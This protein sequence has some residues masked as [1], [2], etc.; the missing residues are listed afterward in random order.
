M[1]KFAFIIHPIDVRRDA[2]RKYPILKLLPTRAIESLALRLAP[3][4]MSHISGIESPTGAQAEGWLIGCPLSPR[5]FLELPPEISYEKIAEAGKLG[6]EKGAKIVGLG[7]FS[8]VAGDAGI[9]VAEK[10]KG[11]INVTSGNSYTVFT[12][13]EGLLHAADLMEVE[14]KNASVAVIG[15]SGSIGAV[16]AKMLATKTGEV[17]LIGRNQEKL[18]AVKSEIE[19]ELGDKKIAQITVAKDAKIALKNADLIL[20]VSSSTDVLIFPEDL[21][22]GAIVCDVARPRD[23]S[24]KVV[25]ERDDVLVIEGGVIEVPGHPNFRFNFGF[26]DKT[27]YACMSET[28]IL[29]LEG[30]YESYTLG[31]DL[32]VE[33]IERMGALARKHGF[34]LAGFRAFEKA[35]TN[36]DIE[37]VRRNAKRRAGSTPGAANAVVATA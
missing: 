18:N 37:R 31:R 20:A 30:S 32:S 3:K 26:P 28:M 36:E 35:V 16:C 12:A 19:S 4:E 11:I 27:A 5:Q 24:K 13:V 2:S 23:V 22:S 9:S 1:E 34:K 15:A 25:E 10:L 14:A 6:A 33:Q 21:K 17:V 7:A 8:S 29:A